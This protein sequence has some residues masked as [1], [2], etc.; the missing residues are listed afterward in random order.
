MWWRSKQFVQRMLSYI[1]RWPIGLWR[2]I[3]W[4]LWIK[5]P[6]GKHAF[7][8]WVAGLV[9]LSFDLT[10]TILFIETLLDV[11]KWKTRPL[12][13]LE[14]EMAKSVFGSQF[15]IQLIAF[16][17]DSIPVK[18]SKT[19]AYVSFHTINASAHI[20]EYV[21]IHELV[22]IWQYH[23]NGS[24]YISEAIWAQK[25]GGGYNYG[26]IELLQKYST[27]KGLSAFNYEQQADIIEDY[28]RWKNGLSLQWAVN[29]PGIGTL[30][31]QY[32]NELVKRVEG[33]G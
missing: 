25:W 29:A 13:V 20:P 8:R 1:L 3:L 2:L 18:R 17:P 11:V 24:A 9:L 6:R 14:K 32:K 10:P 7:V 31:E 28:Y 15:P 27:G 33:E 26:G 12:S 4:L 23:H 19:M 5:S 22:H 21:F 30:L 16:D